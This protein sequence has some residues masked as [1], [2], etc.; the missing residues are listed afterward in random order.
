MN[1]IT[2]LPFLISAILTELIILKS[3]GMCRNKKINFNIWKI[4]LLLGIAILDCSSHLY[5]NEV[6]LRLSTSYILSVI[7]NNLIFKDT[8]KISVFYTTI[9]FL[10]AFICELIL[11]LLI[12]FLSIFNAKTLYN[13][14]AGEFMFSTLSLILILIT[15]KI[16]KKIINFQQVS[17]FL[18]K[19]DNIN[20]IAFILFMLVSVLLLIYSFDFKNIEIF[21][22]TFITFIIIF[23]FIISLFSNAYKKENLIAKNQFLLERNNYFENVRD[24]YRILKHNLIND[25]LSIDAIGNPKVKALVKEKIKKYNKEYDWITDI[26]NIPNNLQGLIQLKLIV[27]KNLGIDCYIDTQLNTNFIDEINMSLYDNLSDAL[28]ITLDNALEA[29]KECKERFVYLKIKEKKHCFIIEI[30]NPFINT[31]DIEALGTKNY[32]TKKRNSG[33]GLFSL[34]KLINKNKITIKN[35]I[36]NN[37]FT[38]L[39]ITQK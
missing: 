17:K 5:N 39:I 19:D 31:I 3:Y 30:V 22:I 10:V 14:Y 6:F 27:A 8:I 18:E 4:L 35:K 13:L 21:V 2:F 23:L 9:I 1:K 26:D 24:N 15:F 29:A 36:V 32:S 38:T 7:L 16:L 34:S 33:I 12:T 20:F 37:I 28:S 11:A 25:L